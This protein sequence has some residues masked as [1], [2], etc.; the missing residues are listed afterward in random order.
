MYPYPMMKKQKKKV[1]NKL[2]QNQE[3]C[4]F[5]LFLLDFCKFNAH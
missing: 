4:M 1:C 3:Q 5:V 2:T